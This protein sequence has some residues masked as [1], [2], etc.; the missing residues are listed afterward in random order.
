MAKDLIFNTD[1]LLETILKKS[2]VKREK[3]YEDAS[4]MIEEMTQKIIAKCA[5]LD[6]SKAAKVKYLF[7]LGSWSHSGDCAKTT[8]KWRHLTAYDFVICLHKETWD[9]L[10]D[11]QKEALL[12]HELSHVGHVEDKWIVVKHDVEEFL[13]TFK[14]YGSWT[15]NLKILEDIRVST[16]LVGVSGTEG[17]E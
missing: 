17:G 16:T 8:G 2:V 9:I 4:P 13:T 3:A 7:R 5:E 10:T 1:M 6:V 11:H 12:H 14:R 15:P